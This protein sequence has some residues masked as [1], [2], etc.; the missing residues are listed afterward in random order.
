MS[1]RPKRKFAML[2]GAVLTALLLTACGAP[3]AKSEPTPPATFQ[4]RDRTMTVLEGVPVQNYDP[5]AFAADGAGR[6]TCPDARQGIDVSVHQKKI[7]WERVAGDGIDFAV[8]RVGYRGA[9]FTLRPVP[10]SRSN[11]PCPATGGNGSPV[12]PTAGTGTG[13]PPPDGRGGYPR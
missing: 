12:P 1:L 7:D 8:L 10:G 6:I 3:V 9:F 2:A 11:P 13:R 4:Y 5:A